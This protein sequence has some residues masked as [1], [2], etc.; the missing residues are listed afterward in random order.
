MAHPDETLVSLNGV[1]KDYPL[2]DSGHGRLRTLWALLRRRGDFPRYR[3][4]ADISFE[5]RRGESLGLIGENG[6][7]KSTL[8]KTIAGVVRQSTGSVD[9]R[10]KV[11]A[12]LELGAGFHPDYTGRENIFL[13][14]ALMGLDREQTRARLDD[15]LAFADIGEHIE[16]PIKHYSSGMVV[17]LGFAI[18]TTMNPDI[19]ITDEVLAVGDESFQKK[20]I[21]WMEA[22]LADGGTLLLCSHGMYHVQK[23]CRKALWLHQGKM[24]AYGDAFDVTQEYLAYHEQKSSHQDVGEADSEHSAIAYAVTSLS[25]ENDDGEPVHAVSMQGSLCIRGTLRSPDG[26]TPVVALG[27]LRA[28]ATP[29]FGTTS[30]IDGVELRPDGAQGYGFCCRLSGLALL[31]GHYTVRAHA[32]DPEGMRVFDTAEV[33]LRVTGQSRELGLVRLEHDWG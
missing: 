1:G 18:A 13:A 25:L 15:I 12:L 23:L 6:A 24:R 7:G 21:A 16:Q 4:L 26:R 11:G 14:T 17:R 31:P 5:V 19:L 33:P 27:I 22:Y 32:M 2:V 30:E 29:I 20:C 9:I 8:L 28:D 10:G 3:A